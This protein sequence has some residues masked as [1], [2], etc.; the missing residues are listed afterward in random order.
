MSEQLIVP[1]NL[2][3]QEKYNALIPQVEALVAGEEDVIANLSNIVAALKYGMNWLWIGV[4]FVK[5]NKEKN[6]DELVLGPYQGPVACTR[7][8]YGRGV[9]GAA[10]KSKE[11][12]IADD[13]NQ[14]PGHIACSDLSKSEIVLPVF[15]NG[16][17]VL[18]LDIDS[19]EYA[20][21][22]TTDKMS[23]NKI[24]TMIESFI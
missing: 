16:E 6:A 4:Y 23:L 9:C 19:D 15:K 13:V 24:T 8:G 11:V 22:D 12:I 14:F 5:K 2:S 20:T 1:L 21:F 3:K 7:I 18:V 10:W 17:V